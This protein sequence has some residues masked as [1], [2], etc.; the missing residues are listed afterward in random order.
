MTDFE[1][2]KQLDPETKDKMKPRY[3]SKNMVLNQ[4]HKIRLNN[5]SYI[6]GW[7]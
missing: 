7:L 1:F 6:L 4:A 5:S 2:Y 3:E